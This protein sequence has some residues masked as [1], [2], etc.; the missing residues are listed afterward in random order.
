MFTERE[1]IKHTKDEFEQLF[2]RGTGAAFGVGGVVA[3]QR[4]G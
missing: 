2:R 1:E 3:P 4:P